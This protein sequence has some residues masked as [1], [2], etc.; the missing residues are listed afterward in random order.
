MD[1]E[2]TG[3]KKVEVVVDDLGGIP[4]ETVI[5]LHLAGAGLKRNVAGG[6]IN[7]LWSLDHGGG[8]H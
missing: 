4:G 6:N 2:G 3:L 1:V 8:L 7:E 5:D